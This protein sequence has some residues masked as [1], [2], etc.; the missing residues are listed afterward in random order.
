[1]RCNTL[2]P[3]QTIMVFNYLNHAHVRPKFKAINSMMRDELKRAQ[4]AY[5]DA[6]DADISLVDCWDLFFSELIDKMVANGKTWVNSAISSMR[7][8]WRQSNYPTD[9]AYQAEA[10]EV[11]QHLD[12]LETSGITNGR[13][14]L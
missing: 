14:F 8:E 1:M 13:D 11:N 9:A 4:D 7:S 3:T 10:L 5:N 2:P 6:N 12:Q